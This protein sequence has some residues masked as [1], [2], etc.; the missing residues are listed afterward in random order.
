LY[1]DNAYWWY[2]NGWRQA[3]TVC[4]CPLK[5][6]PF[7]YYNYV[8]VIGVEDA[9]HAITDLFFIMAAHE[10]GLTSTTGLPFAIDAEMIRWRNTFVKNIYNN[11]LSTPTNAVF[12]N[13]VDGNNQNGSVPPEA[14]CSNATGIY[15]D[16]NCYK[17]EMTAYMPLYLFDNADASAYTPPSVYTILMDL[18]KNEILT[19]IGNMHG[20]GVAFYGLGEVIRA[21]WHKECFDLNLYNRELV[22]DQN[23]YAKHNLTI[24][25]L[26]VDN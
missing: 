21:Q 6:E 2:S 11:S 22:Y 3:R 19:N 16:G 10:L 26:Q 20:G 14:D 5:I 24:N 8:H 7:S 12:K 17:K 4:Y 25:P 15:S 1:G 13:L 23:F 9:S 18:Y